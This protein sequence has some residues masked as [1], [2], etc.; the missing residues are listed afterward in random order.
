MGR[1]VDEL[2]L[3]TSAFAWYLVVT[4]SIFWMTLP[5]GGAFLADPGVDPP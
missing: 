5:P 3:A 4:A 2:G 1:A